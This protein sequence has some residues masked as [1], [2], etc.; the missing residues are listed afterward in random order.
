MCLIASC[1]PFP[2]LNPGEVNVPYSSIF[3]TFS[4]PSSWQA[5]CLHPSV[6]CGLETALLSA[7]ATAAHTPLWALLC[8][9]PPAPPGAPTARHAAPAA[10]VSVCGLLD[11]TGTAAEAAVEAVQ[12]V[13]AQGFTTLKLKVGRRQRWSTCCQCTAFLSSSE[14]VLP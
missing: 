9:A 10:A 11:G 1:I 3:C 4:D 6:R 14:S 12:L 13:Q 8:S 5:E 7:L 2:R